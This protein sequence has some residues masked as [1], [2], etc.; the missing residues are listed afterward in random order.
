MAVVGFWQLG[1]NLPHLS[2]FVLQFCHI[3]G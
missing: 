1:G 3:C 2:P